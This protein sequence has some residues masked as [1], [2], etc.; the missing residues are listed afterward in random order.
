MTKKYI[1][2]ILFSFIFLLGFSHFIF[3]NTLQHGSDTIY[4]T[5]AE[6]TL[7]NV[8]SPGNLVL[9]NNY[10][11]CAI[12][13]DWLPTWYVCVANGLTESNTTQPAGLF[14]ASQSGTEIIQAEMGQWMNLKFV[15]APTPTCADG[16]LSGNQCITLVQ[17]VC[18]NNES[19]LDGSGMCNLDDNQTPS[20]CPTDDYPL[21]DLLEY[22]QTQCEIVYT[23]PTCPSGYTLDGSQCLVVDTTPP[24]TDTDGDGV[25]DTVDNCPAVANPEQ[26]DTDGD[27]IGDACEA[28]DTTPPVITGTFR[29]QDPSPYDFAKV[30]DRVRVDFESN[31]RVYPQSWEIAGHSIPSYTPQNAEG[32]RF[33]IYYDMQASDTEGPLTYSM[34]A[35]DDAGKSTTVTGGGVTFDK[36]APA[37]TVPDDI[38]E[39]TSGSG[40]ILNYVAS[41]T[42]VNPATPEVTCVPPSGSTFP[43]GTTVVTCSATDSA[44]NTGTDT[45]NI[46]VNESVDTIP[47]VEDTT[48][49]VITL[50]G[51]NP[52]TVTIGYTY[53][54]AGATATDDVD[55][56][57]TL[58]IEV[59][60]SVD[61]TT[62]GTYTITYDVIDAAGNKA[63]QVTR[64]VNV[65]QAHK[66]S[67]GSSGGSIPRISSSGT[68]ITGGQVLG[69]EHF[70]FT[71]LLKMGSMAMKLWNFKSS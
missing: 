36:T 53:L 54:D 46:T 19:I 15:Y 7:P 24:S 26:T 56:D 43:L 14:Y 39:A 71:L 21:L 17:T 61:T 9:S 22:S 31:E 57:I 16:I 30:G 4:T 35:Q 12:L 1:I 8:N 11:D 6:N 58:N 18:A 32:T 45:F 13:G 29:R 40:A 49:P 51:D 38:V 48:N 52:V 55:D 50:L 65:I 20:V 25:L 10:T 59:G 3:A 70:N 44:G 33:Y 42:D 47:T 63:N 2:T 69:A 28:P 23:P 41:A 27:G 62:V 66:H 68:V 37:V 60:G 64:T 67:S 34:T 5:Q